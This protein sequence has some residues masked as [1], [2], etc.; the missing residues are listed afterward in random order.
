M[1][2][3]FDTEADMETILTMGFQGGFTAGL[4]NLDQL[5]STQTTEKASR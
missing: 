5:L 1:R 4:G 3:R 2:I